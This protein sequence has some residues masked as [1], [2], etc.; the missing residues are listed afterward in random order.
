M[1]DKIIKVHYRPWGPCSTLA[2]QDLGKRLQCFSQKQPLLNF[3]S[4]V[5][6]LIKMVPSILKNTVSIIFWGGHR[7]CHSCQNFIGLDA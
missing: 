3:F 2:V 1:R 7:M 4:G 5:S 6:Q